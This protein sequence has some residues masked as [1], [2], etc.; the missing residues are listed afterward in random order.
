MTLIIFI[1]TVSFVNWAS[2]NI[3]EIKIASQAKFNPEFHC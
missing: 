2:F 3:I 1:G